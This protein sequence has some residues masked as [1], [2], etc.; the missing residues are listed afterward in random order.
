MHRR[1]C[2]T[3]AL[4][5]GLAWAPLSQ[6]APEA[7][8]REVTINGSGTSSNDLDNNNL[9]VSGSLGKFI[10]DSSEWGVRQLIGFTNSSN[11]D[12]RFSGATR[13]FYD[14]HYDADA[15]QPYVG[16]SLG[17]IYGEDTHETFSAG[18]EA[19]V[20]YYVKDKTFVNVGLEYQFLFDDSSDIDNTYDDGAI[21]YNIGMGYNF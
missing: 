20:K 8:D 19:G 9:S 17:Y 2:F 14:W 12:S 15:W 5:A 6:G 4:L 18:P 10:T 16:A 7:G 21:F 3:C 11:T 13:L 1:I